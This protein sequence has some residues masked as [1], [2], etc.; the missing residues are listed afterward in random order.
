MTC[1]KSTAALS[2][3]GPHTNNDW[4]EMYSLEHDKSFSDSYFTA[5]DDEDLRVIRPPQWVAE[6]IASEAAA[7]IPRDPKL[8]PGPVLRQ[9]RCALGLT[10]RNL[11]KFMGM[12][13][14]SISQQ[15]QQDS[16][17]SEA[18]IRHMTYLCEETLRWEA[19][20]R[21]YKLDFTGTVK[22]DGYRVLSNGIFVHESWWAAL[23]GRRAMQ[24]LS[25]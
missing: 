14:Q 22:K 4:G 24:W 18:V 12:S 13:K 20:I 17:V 9:L 16:P 21:E 23:V 3:S 2:F 1:G 10:Q 8:F 6:P 7:P 19:T 5:Y 11:G 15:E 25:P